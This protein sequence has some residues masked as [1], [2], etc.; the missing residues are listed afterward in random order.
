MSL[1]GHT[2]GQYRIIGSVGTGGMAIVYKAYQP[3]LDRYVAI[4]VLPDHLPIIGM[5]KQYRNTRGPR[6]V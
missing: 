4:K 6:A 1:I 5:D 3:G 2:L